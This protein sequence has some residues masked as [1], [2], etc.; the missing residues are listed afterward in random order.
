MINIVY[1]NADN[2]ARQASDH[3]TI[4]TVN[5]TRTADF[6]IFC[7]AESVEEMPEKSG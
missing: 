4:T 5:V 6:F 3:D 1:K 7:S 2:D